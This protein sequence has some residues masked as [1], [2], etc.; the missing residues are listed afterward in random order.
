MNNNERNKTIIQIAGMRD[1]LTRRSTR[2]SLKRRGK[3]VPKVVK[4]VD[5][6]D[7]DEA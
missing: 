5:S 6:D 2:K 1:E 7:D 4:E 3:S